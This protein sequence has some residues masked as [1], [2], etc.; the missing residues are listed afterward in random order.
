MR[1]GHRSWSYPELLEQVARLAGAF[2][3]LG[4][5]DGD[6]IGVLSHNSDRYFSCYYAVSWAGGVLLPLNYRLSS[7]ELRVV[8]EDAQPRMLICDHNT[9]SLAKE[10]K[11]QNSELVLVYGGKILLKS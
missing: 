4:L 6:R 1:F 8:L 11:A 3:S 7:S 2:R 5:Q 9:L 10:M